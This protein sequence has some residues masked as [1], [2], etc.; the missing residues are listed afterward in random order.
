MATS[1]PRT[2]EFPRTIRELVEVQAHPTV[3][4]LDHLAEPADWIVS[5]YQLT[6]D[7]DRHLA[8]L[9][10]VL[11]RDAGCGMFLIGQY[12]S[13]KSHFLAYLTRAIEAGTLLDDD[14]T[15]PQVHAISLLNFRA[16]M[17][18]E[19]IV[20]GN[21]G[22]DVGSGDRRDA[23]HAATAGSARGVL[24]VL[25]ELSEFLRSK[26]DRRAF[27]EDVRF[28]QFLGEW[29]QDERFWILA[30]MQEQIE[31]TGDLDDDLYRKIKDRYP[32]R[33]FLTPAHVHD[34]VASSIIV[35][36]DGYR[37][38]VERL[39]DE[40]R[41]ALPG[42][43]LD[44]DVLGDVYPVHPATLELLE[45]VRDRFSQ[46]R[47][48]VDFVTTRL[49]GR[50][51]R[52]IPPFLDEPW[53]SLIAPDSIVAHF[54]DLFDFQ[55][56]FLE[57]GQRLLP[58][59]ERCMG[60]IFET[61][62]LSDLASRL[63][64]LLILTHLSPSRAGMTVEE[65]SCWLLYRASRVDST[66][67]LRI[68]ER[69]LD[70]LVEKGRFVARQKGV[71]S[72]R[73]EDD[74]EEIFTRR[75]E[76]EM[77]ELQGWGVGVFEVAVSALDDDGSHPFVLPRDEWQVRQVTWSFHERE[78]RVFFGSAVAQTD[79]PVA[80]CVRL[81]WGEPRP[82]PGVWTLIPEPLDPGDDT[83][84]L[85]ALV[86]L[87]DGSAR[88]ELRDRIGARIAELVDVLRSRL[89]SSLAG[90]R[91][92]GPTGAVEQS[93]R[94]HLRMSL[95]EWLDFH[96]LW[97]LRRRHP[98]FESVAPT[99]GPLPREAY[100]RFL[101][102]LVAH[103]LE[104]AD[105]DDYVQLVRECYLVPMGLLR[106][107]GR[108]YAT[109]SKL[110][111]SALV[112][113]VLPLVNGEPAPGVI[114]EHLASGPHGLVPDQVRLL[115]IVLFAV[116]ELDIVRGESSYRE[117]HASELD[118]LQYDR[119]V[120]GRSLSLAQTRAL[121]QLGEGLGI[122]LPKEWTVTSGRRVIGLLQ[123][124]G[125]AQC[126]TLGRLCVRLEELDQGRK[127]VERLR[128]VITKWRVL[129][130]ETHPFDAL[131]SFLEAISAPTSFLATVVVLGDL[132]ER[133]DRIAADLERFRHLFYHPLIRERR[134]PELAGLLDEVREPPDLD[135]PDAVEAWIERARVTWQE[136]KAEYGRRH[137]AWW[138]K[139]ED[140][141]L[142]SWQA[143]SL[144]RVE[145]LGLGADLVEIEACQARALDL[146]CRDLLNLDFQPLCACGFDGA[147]SPVLVELR[148]F[149]ELRARAGTVLTTFF[150]RRD[151]RERVRQWVDDG[152][153]SAESARAYLEGAEPLPSVE[154][155]DLLDRH[156]G[157]SELVRDI[158]LEALLVDLHGRTWTREELVE[159]LERRL[160]RL[161]AKRVRL[162]CRG[163][164][165]RPASADA[166]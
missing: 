70:A 96:A 48:V 121:E 160:E 109:P 49:R 84:E 93:P 126:E 41:E 129:Q 91:I 5:A 99:A 87:R 114:A 89:R 56:E 125:R 52:G 159:E 50:E 88:G 145:H 63:I 28:L 18:L 128:D 138:A 44:L 17:T 163:E 13:G 1:E 16:E 157:G 25:D 6:P 4:R 62:A 95:R 82:A 79:A 149:E 29:A 61:S 9:R 20:A 45:E 131:A 124:V 73:L 132:P 75:V 147:G 123:A 130:S 86:R 110:D 38:M 141:E 2:I 115:L 66:L 166:G 32:L 106:R 58:W 51:D 60:E 68:V 69:V 104:E 139:L 118:P 15:A 107:K 26:R 117:T 85:A 148:R 153:G 101:R 111:T 142:W 34:L 37:E 137:D 162:V 72:L 83:V 12:G 57:I 105:G 67:N 136:Y 21:L 10:H 43:S 161:G 33:Y 53:G 98:S 71:Y 102:F 103:G 108:R 152:P 77:Q 150:A 40:I 164:G 74:G 146:R 143:H 22:V 94:G 27:N 151:V 78:Y 11:S 39:V 65:A 8:S 120:P 42:S 81:P 59:Y 97:I 127:L 3:V 76:R 135:D 80:L 156:L 47:G 140:H 36:R 35:K 54:R 19:D 112:R 144:M 154:D 46:A 116:G 155:V 14:A 119:I 23:W 24:L 158:D 122:K 134:V 92:V 100:R 90:A 31:H 30:A 113:S 7:V 55:P 133:F 165:E 64:D